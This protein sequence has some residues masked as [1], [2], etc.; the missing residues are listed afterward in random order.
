MNCNNVLLLVPVYCYLSLDNI[1]N[2]VPIDLSGNK[3]YL[4]FSFTN[5][6]FQSTVGT[7]YFSRSRKIVLSIRLVS[8]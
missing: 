7:R 8:F 6:I 4:A 2:K 1:F 5:V 3:K